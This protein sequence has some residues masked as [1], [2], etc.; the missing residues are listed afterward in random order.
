MPDPDAGRPLS[1][2]P[3]AA[4]EDPRLPAFLA[5]PRR[6]RAVHLSE[7]R[8]PDDRRWGV[9]AVELTGPMRTRDD[10]RR[11]LAEILDLLRSRWLATHP[12]PP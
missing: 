12:D 11:N 10:A 8:P 4:S 5:R 6:A 9:Y 3:D 7:V 1:L 2:D